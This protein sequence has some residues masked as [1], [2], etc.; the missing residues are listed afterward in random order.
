MNILKTIWNLPTKVWVFGF[1]VVAYAVYETP[2][3]KVAEVK[4]QSVQKVYV[5]ADQTD[6]VQTCV[7]TLG[8]GTLKNK[9]IQWKIGACTNDYKYAK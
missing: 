2:E 7:D 3:V 6:M 5:L 9:S 1:V 8:N 4:E